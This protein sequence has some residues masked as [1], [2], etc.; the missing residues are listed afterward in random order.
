MTGDFQGA[1]GNIGG[2][3][4]GAGFNGEGDGDSSGAGADVEDGSS[5]AGERCFDQV[6]GFGAG[7]EDVGRD[8][9]L[10]AVKFLNSRDVLSRRSAEALMKIAAVVDPPDFAE[11][12]G[13]MSVEPASFAADG[14]GE[15]DF[16]GEARSGNALVF[17]EFLSLEKSGAEV[18]SRASGLR[19][20]PRLVLS[21]F[22]FE[23][24]G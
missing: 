6:L 14:V 24:A 15:Q 7:D 4:A 23:N 11:F 9:E 17:E 20:G 16:G 5:G 12:V 18:R 21:I 1:L 13:R 8:A 3:D 10:A 19:P 22:R 2:D